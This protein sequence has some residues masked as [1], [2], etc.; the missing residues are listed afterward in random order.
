MRLTVAQQTI[1]R[2]AL[3]GE[4]RH[5]QDLLKTNPDW[6]FAKVKIKELERVLEILRRSN[7]IEVSNAR[8]N[9][10]DDSHRAL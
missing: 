9:K 10:N 8:L 6:M 5:W 1:I 3:G 7:Y 4:I 2:I